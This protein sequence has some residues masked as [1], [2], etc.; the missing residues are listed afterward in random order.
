MK[1]KVVI[2]VM[3]LF[4][5]PVVH[6]QQLPSAAVNRNLT[7]KII[8]SENKTWDYNIYNDGK[9]FIHQPSI[10]ALPGNSG[11]TT[12][13]ITEKVAKKVIDKIKSGENPPTISIEE[14]KEL[15]AI[16]KQ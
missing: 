3:M 15:G 4:T 10:P 1:Q 13:I 11:F 8:P 7:Y 2:A 16:P 12:K 6:A 9:L 14:L 5:L